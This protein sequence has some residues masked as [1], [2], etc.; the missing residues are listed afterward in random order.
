M[1]YID[2]VSIDPVSEFDELY[3]NE[4]TYNP[5]Y[6]TFYWCAPYSYD[7]VWIAALALNCTETYL[8]RIGKQIRIRIVVKESL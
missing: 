5:A 6:E 8:R 4:K 1:T 7:H 2:A 3:R